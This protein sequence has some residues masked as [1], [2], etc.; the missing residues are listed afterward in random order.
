MN[1]YSHRVSDALSEYN[2]TFDICRVVIEN[3]VFKV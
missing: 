2:F 1:I 3:L